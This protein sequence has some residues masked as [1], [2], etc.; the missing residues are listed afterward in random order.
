MSAT[1]T[2]RF[3][4]EPSEGCLNSRQKHAYETVLNSVLSRE[5]RYFIWE[6][7]QDDGKA[8]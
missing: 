1:S 7:Y 6:G 3:L 8:G 2:W 5:V 4:G